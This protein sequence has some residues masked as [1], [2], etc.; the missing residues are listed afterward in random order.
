MAYERKLEQLQRYIPFLRKMITKLERTN[1]PARAAQL[2]KMRHLHGILTDR[3]R[4]YVSRRPGKGRRRELLN[5]LNPKLREDLWQFLVQR[6]PEHHL[7]E[8]QNPWLGSGVFQYW[9]CHD[10]VILKC[11]TRVVRL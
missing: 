9:S 7:H 2:Q 4:K 8:V 10:T 3:T 11:F 1:D 6:T 5:S